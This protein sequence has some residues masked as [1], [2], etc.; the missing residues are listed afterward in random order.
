VITKIK[1]LN[2][3]MT[4]IEIMVAVGILAAITLA[5]TFFALDVSDFS[6]NLGRNL[7]A[8]QEIN[9]TFG[10]LISEIRSIGPAEDG[11]F[12]IGQAATSSFSFYTDIDGNG[13]FDKVRYFLDKGTFKKGVI[14]P[15]GVPAGYDPVS[16]T[17]SET[18]H[19]VILPAASTT[20]FAYFD[21]DYSG[22][23]S[24]MALPVNISQIRLVKVDITIDET[25]LDVAG[26]INSSMAALIRNLRYVE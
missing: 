12:M 20:I 15:S 7:S 10:I 21:K 3:G 14:K 9:L 22:A 1:N 6:V 23:G 2:S 16:E 24:P 18:I 17:I 11:S 13:S 26:R 4:L 5:V 8:Q 19:N 25:P